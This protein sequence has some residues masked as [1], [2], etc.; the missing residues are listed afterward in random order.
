MNCEKGVRGVCIEEITES[1][2]ST[3]QSLIK[4]LQRQFGPQLVPTAHHFPVGYMKG[5]TKVS[6]RTPAGIANI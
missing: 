5:S 3:P 4:E 1:V 6:I 2:V